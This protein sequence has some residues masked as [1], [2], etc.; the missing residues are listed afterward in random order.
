MSNINPQTTEQSTLEEKAI[1]EYQA[2]PRGTAEDA[3]NFDFS[4]PLENASYLKEEEVADVQEQQVGQETPVALNH[5]STDL[6]TLKDVL[7]LPS[8]RGTTLILDTHPET[9][10][11]IDS[12]KFII[13]ADEND[14]DFHDPYN[15]LLRQIE[16]QEAPAKK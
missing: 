4:R 7:T 13:P 5:E 16:A 6:P 1:A 8:M 9:G 11:E 15:K 12:V 2:F 14:P 3:K 10:A